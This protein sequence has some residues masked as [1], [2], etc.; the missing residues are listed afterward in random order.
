MR[1][2]LDTNVINAEEII[3]DVSMNICDV[4]NNRERWL[5]AIDSYEAHFTNPVKV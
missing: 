5:K 1:Q 4:R 3:K 2:L